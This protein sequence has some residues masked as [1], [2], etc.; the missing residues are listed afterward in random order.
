ML[1]TTQLFAFYELGII[2]NLL[3]NTQKYFNFFLRN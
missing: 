2:L 1:Q 3:L